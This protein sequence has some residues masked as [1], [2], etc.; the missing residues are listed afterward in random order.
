MESKRR[1][2]SDIKYNMYDKKIKT[3]N[4]TI[5]GNSNYYVSNNKYLVHNAG[6][7]KTTGDN[8]T[9]WVTQNDKKVLGN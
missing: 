9:P 1:T 7:S 3:Y 8:V 5:E 6:P 2:I 4:L